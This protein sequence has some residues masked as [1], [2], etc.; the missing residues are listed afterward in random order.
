MAT[1]KIS[2]E[3]E[4]RLLTLA[5]EGDQ[6]AFNE[7]MEHHY[8]YIWN[9]CKKY[10]DYEEDTE[11]AVQETMLKIYEHLKSFREGSRL[12]T[13]IFVIAK[14]CAIAN[15]SARRRTPS[16]PHNNRISHV[17]E[18]LDQDNDYYDHLMSDDFTEFGTN[19]TSPED[20]IIAMQLGDNLFN[21]ISQLP[22]DQQEALL[23][24][25]IELKHYDEISLETDV[26]LGT[27][28]S[29]IYNAREKLDK[30]LREHYESEEGS[31]KRFTAIG[32]P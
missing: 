1:V 25:E 20:E 28:K 30:M 3:E 5:K 6:R 29:R 19:H 12:S 32:A 31:N 21:L 16:H 2:I 26:C 4:K 8:K 15:L 23:L 17:S 18:G 14:N 24:R 13:W 22:P 9:C 10:T 7:L 27:V 11:E